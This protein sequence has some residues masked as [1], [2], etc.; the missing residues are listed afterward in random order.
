MLLYTTL[1]SMPEKFKDRYRIASA[2][3]PHWDYGA[4]G[5]Y[6]V[7]I[8]TQQMECFFGRIK[9]GE[10]HLSD[11]GQIAH[12]YWLEIPK[13]FPFIR[14]ESFIVMPNHVHGI[15]V[16]DKQTV[17]SPDSQETPGSGVSTGSENNG[18]SPDIVE[19]T[20]LG[21]SSQNDNLDSSKQK[22][23]K[24]TAKASKVWQ[25]GTLG[26]IINQYKRKCT[27]ESRKTRPGFK[28]QARFHDHIIRD[29]KAFYRI[30]EYIQ[31][32]PLVWE[33]DK[34]YVVY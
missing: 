28:W 30:S 33:K 2:R 26:V 32:N 20:N 1:L 7:T 29:E 34:F 9:E 17:K 5:Y 18:Q 13:H 25:P 6:F 21:V 8:C 19:T 23:R 16:I 15:L 3:H 11:T 12:D 24:Q 27:I 10:M 31:N 22:A 14:L 4:D